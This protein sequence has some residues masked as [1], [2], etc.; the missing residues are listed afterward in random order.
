MK[1]KGRPKSK[2]IE[3]MRKDFYDSG[4]KWKHKVKAFRM[5]SF[6]AAREFSGAKDYNKFKK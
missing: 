3:D 5:E 2:N 6:K 4:M 1:T